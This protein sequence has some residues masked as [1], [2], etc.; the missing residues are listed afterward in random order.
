MDYL[1]AV[2]E[3]ADIP[4]QGLVITADDSHI[5]RLVFV[6]REQARPKCAGEHP[7]PLH[8]QA[9]MQIADYLTGKRQAFSLPTRVTGTDFQMRV[10]AAIGSIPYGETRTYGEIGRMLGD[11]RLARAVGN[12]ANRNPL[13]LI[14][15][16]HRVIGSNGDLTGFACGTATKAYLLA[17]EQRAAA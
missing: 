4:L 6:L 16:C 15:P 9:A 7:R 14:V 17:L 13:P 5:L 10:W 1:A 2:P 11:V 12:A 8:L 3:G